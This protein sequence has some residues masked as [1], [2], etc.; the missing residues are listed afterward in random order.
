MGWRI[1]RRLGQ[2]G[3]QPAVRLGQRMVGQPG[4]QVVQRVEAQ[5]HRRPQHAGEGGR[6]VGAVAILIGQRQLLAI[7][8]PQMRDQRAR[9]VEQRNARDDRAIQREGT[10]RQNAERSG[11]KDGDR[12]HAGR[13]LLHLPAAREVTLGRGAVVGRV[14]FERGEPLDDHAP[15]RRDHPRQ[16]AENTEAQEHQRG[17]RDRADGEQRQRPRAH[18]G[19]REI[20]GIALR[21]VMRARVVNR[22]DAFVEERGQHQ[23]RADPDVPREAEAGQLAMVEMGDLV[24]EQRRSIQRQD[25]DQHERGGQPGI[26]AGNR[27]EQRGIADRRRSEA[28]APVHHR[29]GRMQVA[30]Q[31]CCLTQHFLVF[32]SGG[33][34]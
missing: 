3:A 34:G 8:L 18:V 22:V 7:I 1:G 19:E 29:V 15:Q 28:I 24:N 33:R 26:P 30:R 17:H 6:H 9:L 10:Q 27:A 20:F 32:R 13:S 12:D 2:R 5:A 31:H 16:R 23:R 11:R 21:P 14:H 25:R 4:Q